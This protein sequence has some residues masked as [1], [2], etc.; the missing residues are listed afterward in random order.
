M[1]EGVT[2]NAI[3]KIHPT[4]SPLL[5]LKRKK[6]LKQKLKMDLKIKRR[7]FLPNGKSVFTFL[8]SPFFP[9]L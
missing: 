6:Q 4:F 1:K 2:P 9:M 8:N 7:H 5:E 3:N